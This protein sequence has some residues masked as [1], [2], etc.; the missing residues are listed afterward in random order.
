MKRS[1]VPAS[2]FVSAHA[3]AMSWSANLRWWGSLEDFVPQVDPARVVRADAAVAGVV[4]A[5]KEDLEGRPVGKAA[6]PPV[7]RPVDLSL[8]GGR[9]PADYHRA[10]R[11]GRVW[12][13]RSPFRSTPTRRSASRPPI[14]GP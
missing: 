8:L 13:S 10:S 11:R 14:V 6:L 5:V 2:T 1:R 9:G 7:E 3:W 12:G 4:I